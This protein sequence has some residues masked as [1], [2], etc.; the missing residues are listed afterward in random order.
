MK[1]EI[2][3]KLISFNTINDL[4]NKEI[5]EYIISL[6]EQKGFKVQRIFNSDKTKYSVLLTYEEP[7][8][9]FTGHTDTVDRSDKWNTNPF[10][11][12][13]KDGKYYGLGVCDMKGGIAAFLSAIMELDL[14]SLNK[15]LSVLLTFDE[16][17]NFTGA[18]IVDPRLLANNIIIAEPTDNIPVI[19]E[20]GI[21]DIKIKFNGKSVHSSLV[22]YGD[23]AILKAS[24]FINKVEEFK[25]ELKK[26]TNNLYEIPYCT[27]NIGK[28]TGGVAS[29][30]VPDYC[31]IIMDTRPIT[32]NQIDRVIEFLEQNK[33]EIG[34][35][36]EIIEKLN[37]FLLK[38]EEIVKNYEN[39]CNRK[40]AMFFGCT[41]APFFEKSNT[42]IL[43]PG[44][45]TAHEPNESIEVEKYNELIEMYKKIILYY[46]K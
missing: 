15:G 31:E 16:E 9:T 20:K 45:V 32:I 36:Y 5:N 30:I 41:E 8:L 39:I 38:D 33:N 10:D 35:E 24:R 18:K 3:R 17:I 12:I 6:L 7:N 23:N 2:L 4:E 14:E 40:R 21:T 46:C 27:V 43:G 44:S 1:E 29:N 42:L 13:E 25:E 11:L 34:Y 19:G 22:P 26:E 37:P 28:I